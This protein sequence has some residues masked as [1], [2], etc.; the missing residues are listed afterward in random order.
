MMSA[1]TRMR[2]AAAASRHIP[3]AVARP[4]AALTHKP[5]ALVRPRTG[6]LRMVA[7]RARCA[8]GTLTLDWG[9]SVLPGDRNDIFV[10]VE[11][12]HLHRQA[13]Q[14]PSILI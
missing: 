11:V 1:T 8:A 14:C 7:W 3:N 4:T 13:R 5:A 2:V 6:A 9:V 12:A 10:C